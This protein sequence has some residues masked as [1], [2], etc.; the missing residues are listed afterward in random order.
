LPQ[1]I[2][3]RGE[4]SKNKKSSSNRKKDKKMKGIEFLSARYIECKQEYDNSR[5]D[6]KGLKEI[7]GVM[8][9]ERKEIAK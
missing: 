4:K 1:E 5:Y 7:H 2:Q 9:Q 3:Y 8:M 6:E